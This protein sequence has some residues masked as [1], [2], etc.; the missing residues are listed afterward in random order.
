MQGS[1]SNSRI[2]RDA[3]IPLFERVQ[4]TIRMKDFGRLREEYVVIRLF[5]WFGMIR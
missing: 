1:L 4:N 3:R 2:A 5:G